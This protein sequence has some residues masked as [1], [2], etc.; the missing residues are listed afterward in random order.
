MSKSQTFR[1]KKVMLFLSI[2]AAIMVLWLLIRT[3]YL[4]F[5]FNPMYKKPAEMVVYKYGQTYQLTRDDEE[6]QVLYQQ[7]HDAWK[8]DDI[9]TEN[10][11]K[12]NL[13]GYEDYFFDSGLVVQVNYNTT[14]TARGAG[15][16]GAQYDNLVFLLDYPQ[17]LPSDIRVEDKEIIMI[18]LLRKGDH[19][20]VYYS[21][22][23]ESYDSSFRSYHYPQEAK[24]YIL[25]NFN[26]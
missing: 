25:Q 5:C 20:L 15:N 16:W 18:D 14:Q 12:G 4:F 9:W 19:Y 7:L 3:I 2:I 13:V 21:K 26:D 1:K 10:A 11:V 22:K 17:E 6:Y 8:V 24:D 23:D